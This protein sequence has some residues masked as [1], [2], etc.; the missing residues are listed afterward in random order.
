MTC[1]IVHCCRLQSNNSL[2]YREEFRVR[3][4]TAYQEMGMSRQEAVKYPKIQVQSLQC[5][6]M[7]SKYKIFYIYPER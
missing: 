7:Y 6:E 5:A 4:L 2:L 1:K 3:T